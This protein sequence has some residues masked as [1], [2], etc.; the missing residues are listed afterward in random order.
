ML[1]ALNLRIYK[2]SISKFDKNQLRILFI[3]DIQSIGAN[4]DKNILKVA[5]G[6]NVYSFST[7]IQRFSA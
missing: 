5:F 1:Q 2:L 3:C 6:I 4:K 7:D